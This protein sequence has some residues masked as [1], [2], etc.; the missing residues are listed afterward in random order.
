MKEM[1]K[2]FDALQQSRKKCPWSKEQELQEHFK[3]LEREIEEAKEALDKKDYA[4]LKEEL[5]D[6]LM[7]L[8]FI[9]I[10]AEEEKLFSLQD[11]MESANTKLR[12]R[13]PWVF[14]DEKI[15]TKQEAIKRWNE[16]KS[17][18]KAKKAT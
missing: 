13:K 8:V 10:I 17:E 12:R 11:M 18:E 15:T 6:V 9:S 16:I 2:L 14:G 5:G 1:Q 4:N 3:E 7:D